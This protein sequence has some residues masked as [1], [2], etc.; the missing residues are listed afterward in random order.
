MTGPT[1][2]PG[3]N[4]ISSGTVLY[5]D[6]QPSVTQDVPAVP[7]INYNLIDKAN[8]TAQITITSSPVPYT[9]ASLQIANFTTLAGSLI[10]TEIIG[11]VWDIVL[12]AS[13]LIPNSVL[14]YPVICSV[15]ADGVSNPIPIA[16]GNPAGAIVITTGSPAYYVYSLY[17]PT[18]TLL[19]LTK[20]VQVQIW[21]RYIV[22]GSNFTIYMRD[23]TQSYVVSTI[24]ANLFGPTG[25][26][27]PTGMTGPTGAVGNT[28]HT[29]PTGHTGHTGPTGPTGHTGPMTF[30]AYGMFQSATGQILP[31]ANTGYEMECEIT[32]FSNNVTM[33]G[34]LGG[35]KTRLTFAN[36]GI[37]NIQFSS[38]F[39]NTN[40]QD[41]T[42]G[43]WF[44]QQGVDLPSSNSYYTIAKPS[45]SGL[46]V[47]ALNIFVSVTAGQYVEIV[48]ACDSTSVTMH[49]TAAVAPYP[50]SPSV[51]ITAQQV[52]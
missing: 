32:D 40:A 43:V 14:Y 26:T 6:G 51:I 24:A 4:G 19:D 52:A 34:L 10:S 2:A 33:V 3:I 13:T 30:G 36:A 31:A 28:G 37:Y 27:G 39:K 42:I 50:A 8:E 17:V 18:T 45:V 47:A 29:G 46:L 5:L 1:G 25:P 7:I 35:R 20:R 48:W 9:N 41:H 44:R 15:D 11:G 16:S 22:V 49:Y 12:C 21:A 23:S 38:Q